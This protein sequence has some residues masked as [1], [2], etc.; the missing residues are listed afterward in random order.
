MCS[1]GCADR[2]KGVARIDDFDAPPSPDGKEVL[3]P[4]SRRGWRQWLAA[5]V[6]RRDG[7]WVVYRKTT[8]NLDG[9]V[10]DDL[11]EEALC[12]GWIDSRV[13]R[14]DDNRLI[15]WFSPR[16]SGGLWS[17][18]NKERLA[19]LIAAGDMTEWGQSAI[20]QAKADG[21]WSQLDDID[22]LVVPP[23]LRT[24]LK[25]VPGAEAAYEGLSNS[26]KKQHLW[27]IKSAKRPATRSSRIAEIVRRLSSEEG[28]EPS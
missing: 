9:P 23:D 3:I 6:E 17:A 27:W 13:R 21:S 24:A 26:A 15:Q 18:V 28:H 19:R 7:L 8:S 12:F 4:S 11:V 1:H 5:N 10:Y 16:R 25:G 14:I 2:V 20:D 22:A